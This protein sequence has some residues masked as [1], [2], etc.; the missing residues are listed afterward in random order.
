MSRSDR[1]SARVRAPLSAGL[2]VVM[3]AGFAS[4]PAPATAS[5][6]PGVDCTDGAEFE[7]AALALA[8]SCS[9]QV[10]ITGQTSE[11]S[12]AWALPSGQIQRE[13][14]VA[15]VRVRQGDTWAPLDLTLEPRSDGT[16]APRAH[17]DALTLSGG[18]TDNG[19]HELAVLGDGDGQVAMGWTGPLP[20][21]T[22]DGNKATY[23]EVKP[24]VDLVVEATVK[25]VES[26]YVV[27]DRTAA[28][29]VADLTVPITGQD[30]ASHRLTTDGRL[31]LLGD[32]QKAVAYSSTPLMWDSRT[33]STTGEPAHVLAMDSEAIT[34]AATDTSAQAEPIEAAGV[35]LAITPDVEF[36]ADPTTVYPVTI[37]P[38]LQ[39]DDPTWDTWVREGTTTDLSTQQGLQIGAF[40]GNKA[41]AFVNF[42]VST[43]KGKHITDATVGFYNYASNSCSNI[44]WEIWTVNGSNLDTRWTNQ[45][46]WKT[47][48]ATSSA[49]KA[50]PSCTPAS[51]AG[52]V[53]INGVNFFQRQADEQR[54][55]GYMGVRGDETTAATTAASAKNFWSQN[56]T[57]TSKSPYAIITYKDAP[58]LSQRGLALDN[59]DTQFSSSCVTG[60]GRPVVHTLTPQMWAKFTHA[61]D[62]TVS[63]DF[64]YTDLAGNPLGTESVN[65][66]D[67]TENAQ[68]WIAADK[69]QSGGSY[70]WRVRGREDGTAYSSGYSP[71]CEFTVQSTFATPDPPASDSGDNYPSLTDPS[72][73]ISDLV[74]EANPANEIIP[75]LYDGIE[76]VAPDP[77]ATY[78]AESSADEA[79][80]GYDT[81][82]AL[83]FA[84]PNTTNDLLTTAVTTPATAT[85]PA[86]VD[87]ST[88]DH[89]CTVAQD[90][91]SVQQESALTDEESAAENTAYAADPGAYAAVPEATTASVPVGGLGNVSLPGVCKR[92]GPGSWV[93]NRFWACYGTTYTDH[94]AT[95]ARSP[96]YDGSINYTVWRFARQAPRSGTWD[97]H[98]IVNVTSVSPSPGG[99]GLSKV[100]IRSKP[101]YCTDRNGNWLTCKSRLDPSSAP[102]KSGAWIKFNATANFAVSAGRSKERLVAIP[103]EISRPN[104]PVDHAETSYSPRV[105]CDQNLPENNTEGC[106][107]PNLLPALVY[108]K[109]EFKTLA[110]HIVAAQRSGLPGKSSGA[111]LEDWSGSNNRLTRLTSQYYRGLNGNR[112]CKSGQRT[113]SGAPLGTSCDEY[114]PRSTYQGAYTVTPEANS[115]R[116]FRFC[117]IT[118]PQN[119]N[120]RSGRNGYSRCF[121]DKDD[122]IDG[123]NRLGVFYSSSDNGGQRLIDGDGYFI[124]IM[125]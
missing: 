9:H 114:P 40:A 99:R 82:T 79:E 26:F 60:S 28:A 44:N 39:L 85:C 70:R 92:H 20:L 96:S 120:V 71:W 89:S 54:N 52:M 110:N 72:T 81:D 30:V 4:A 38:T 100:R 5:P 94:F 116:W 104:Q 42:D 23:A 19:T 48:E 80:S 22:L 73:T 16:V 51:A 77:N 58:A 125:A 45:P 124:M 13:I 10:E 86:N 101:A 24:G 15:P 56:Y 103:W 11:T 90:T 97:Y 36:L 118:Q 6:A 107:I 57:D 109:S 47:K 50:G 55:I 7:S 49:T 76:E 105:R 84:G 69:L 123:G 46:T 62:T 31:T 88:L 121:I 43:L 8:L 68:A 93:V 111:M 95:V 75:G 108:R 29:Q 35:D 87:P 74:A 65:A 14:S 41:R 119:E 27:K 66:V 3:V 112:A 37:D 12:R 33:D 67:I 18:S 113:T 102:M 91:A 122:N 78:A 64:E 117:N 1:L 53:Y 2:S 17:P 25:G 59:D 61:T 63:A 83:T 98:V 32:D 34:R 115:P 106:V 21:P